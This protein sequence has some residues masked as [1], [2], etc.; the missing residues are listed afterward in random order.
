MIVR[1][2]TQLP[3]EG[4]LLPEE[5]VQPTL[6]VEG[7]YSGEILNDAGRNQQDRIYTVYRTR[8]CIIYIHIYRY[9]LTN[10]PLRRPELTPC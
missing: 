6:E 1:H 5:V 3:A 7:K 4:V 2:G 10:R 9:T 8:I